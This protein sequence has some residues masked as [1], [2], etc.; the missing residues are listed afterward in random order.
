MSNDTKALRN[1]KSVKSILK[2][3]PGIGR[4]LHVLHRPIVQARLFK[5]RYPVYRG[6]T[7]RAINLLTGMTPIEKRVFFC[8][9]PI[10]NN[11]GDQAQTNCIRNWIGEN[12][13]DFEVIELP[14]WPFYNKTFKGMFEALIHKGNMIIVQSGYCTSEHHY[15]HKVH[16]YLASH[17]DN[18]I[19]IMPQTVNFYN[20]KEGFKTG[21]IYKK[22]KKLLFLARDK[23]SYEYAEKYFSGCKILLYPD[24]V[25]SLIGTRSYEG[26]RN[27]VLLCVRNDGEKLYSEE[28]IRRLREKFSNRGI[29]VEITDTNYSDAEKAKGIDTLIE[30]KIRAFSTYRVII[31]DRYHGTIFS[32]VANTPVIVLSTNDHKVKTGTEWFKGIYDGAY[33]NANSIEEAYEMAMKIVEEKPIIHNVAYFKENYY[34]KLHVEFENMIM[35]NEACHE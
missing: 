34:D 8:A 13:P 5:E 9:V 18:P 17:F 35:R 27:G 24:I 33:F 6:E 19:L 26:E 11:L 10:H 31:T 30:D 12:Y 2:K 7:R 22:H 4:A 1:V 21:E 3:L 32:M 25:T 28:Q 29:K 20:E 23:K 15:N 16:R 14:A